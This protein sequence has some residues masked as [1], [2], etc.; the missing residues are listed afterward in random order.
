MYINIKTKKNERNIGLEILRMLL[1]FWVVLFHSVNISNIFI[2]N[3][4]VQKKFHVPC[5]FFMS[6]YFFFPII[7][8]R[9]SFKMKLR[10]ER[11]FIPYALWPII[12][13]CFNNI[14]YMIFKKN[15]F[16]RLLSFTELKVQ[17]IIGRKFFIQ[18]WFLFNLLFQSLFFYIISFFLKKNFLIFVILLGMIFA[19]FQY[20]KYNYIFFLQYKD[21]ISHSI[22]HFVISF[23]IAVVAFCV[24]KINLKSYFEKNYVISLIIIFIFLHILFIIGTPNTY[25]GIDKIVFALFA[26][27]G[28]SLIPL[29]KYLKDHSKNIIY[30]ITN[31]TQGIYCLHIMIKI[32]IIKLFNI[33]TSFLF[34]IKLYI[35]CY[36]LSFIG[37]KIFEKNKLKYLFI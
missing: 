14:F 33:K 4:I 17:L 20:S 6:F 28:F 5:F 2:I 27:I 23:P 32:Y 1:C 31:Y 16:G 25:L 21:S 12:S 10:L 26:F 30:L 29:N 19:I 36:I 34:C 22:G 24:K 11:L 13:W 35:I 7:N 18:L 37:K 15:R 8:D 9:N 3:Y